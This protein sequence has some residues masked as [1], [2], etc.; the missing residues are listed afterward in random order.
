MPTG[1][2][3]TGLNWHSGPCRLYYEISSL[4]PLRRQRFPRNPAWLP[5]FLGKE[6][7]D[8]AGGAPGVCTWSPSLFHIQKEE[9]LSLKLESAWALLCELS[10]ENKILTA[11]LAYMPDAECRRLCGQSSVH[12]AFFIRTSGSLK[13]RCSQPAV[14][15]SIT[16]TTK[17][18]PSFPV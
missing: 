1:V 11:R 8:Q 14:S 9:A 6:F 12:C 4:V 2:P 18:S 16:R 10:E 3:L 15:P 17:P 13:P 5:A 7:E